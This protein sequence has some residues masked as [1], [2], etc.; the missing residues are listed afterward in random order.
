[1]SDPKERKYGFLLG[2]I[3]CMALAMIFAFSWQTATLD[4]DSYMYAAVAKDIAEGGGWLNI[5]DPGYGGA[6]YFHFPLAIWITALLFKILGV[7]LLT[8]KLFSMTSALF[9]C[10][11]IFYFGRRLKNVWVGFFAAWSFLLTNHIARLARQCRMDLPLIFF[12]VLALFAFYLAQ[13]RSRYYYLLFGLA[14]CL[15][16]F[17]KDVSG[18]A[19]L[20]IAVLYLIFRLKFKELFHPLFIAG[21]IIAVAPVWGW[22]FLEYKLYGHTLFQKW[23]DWNFRHLAFSRD[24]FNV[25]WYYYIWAVVT[26]YWY[27]LPFALHGAY[28]A[29]KEEFRRQN[30]G[31]LIPV[32]WAIFFPAAF[33]FGAQK[34]HYF[35]LPMYAACALLV[36]LSFDRLLNEGFKF[37]FA[38]AVKYIVIIMTLAILCLPLKLYKVRFGEIVKMAPLINATLKEAGDYEFLICR[39]DRSAAFFYFRDADKHKNFKDVPSLEKELRQPS[40]KVRFCY[41]STRDFQKISQET[42]RNLRILLRYEDYLFVADKDKE[43]TVHLP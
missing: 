6:F 13:R 26:K 35:V 7:N 41:I 29:V 1:M 8:A 4:G 30:E 15:A 5:Y 40:K 10:V 9:A 43:P 20:L 38:K 18:S 31:W 14:S 34:I 17:T 25:P 23:F 11:L 3:I 21:C 28:L 22:I 39:Y 37:R 2:Y 33:S 24:R 42:R 16:I 36:G 19:P 12:I 27:F 32:I